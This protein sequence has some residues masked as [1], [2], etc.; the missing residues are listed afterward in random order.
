MCGL[1][2]SDNITEE[3]EVVFQTEEKCLQGSLLSL[4]KQRT[5]WG[6]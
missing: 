2:N 4:V 6:G 1:V 5:F 3:L